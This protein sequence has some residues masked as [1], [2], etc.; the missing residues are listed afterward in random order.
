MFV[1]AVLYPT[2]M[3]GGRIG[4]LLKLNPVTPIIDGYRA[5]LLRG[6]SPFTPAFGAAAVISVGVFV[7][8]W[9]LFHRAEFEFAESI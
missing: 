1:T 3:V 6:Q 8:A 9:L 7:I 5:V 2:D 4:F